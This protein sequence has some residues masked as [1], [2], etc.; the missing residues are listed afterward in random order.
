MYRDTYIKLVLKT[1]LQ[2][3]DIANYVY[4]IVEKEEIYISRVLHRIRSNNLREDIQI[5]Y[6]GFM[7]TAIFENMRFNV[8]DDLEPGYSFYKINPLIPCGYLMN[9]DKNVPERFPICHYS[10]FN[11][12]YNGVM[13]VNETRK[14][15]KYL[16][17]KMILNRRNQYVNLELQ[18][19][20]AISLW[21]DFD[22][23]LISNLD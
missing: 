3:T 1:L 9:Y 2:N 13:I 4:Q 18:G 21:Y 11:T 8:D 19:K 16:R 6:P 7:R 23:G 20:R 10:D 17:S 12:D 22:N 15:S 5:L 14:K